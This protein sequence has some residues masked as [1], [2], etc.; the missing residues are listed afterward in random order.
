MLFQK[1]MGKGPASM[2]STS[3]PKTLWSWGSQYKGQLGLG[4][5]VSR[6]SPVQVG[7]VATWSTLATGSNSSR[8]GI[9]SDG[10]L[11]AWGYGVDG[12]LGLGDTVSR[13]SPVQIGALTTWSSVASGGPHALGIKIDGTLWA[14]GTNTTYDSLGDGTLI[15]RSSPVQI[16]TLGTWSSV[17]VGNSGNSALKSD[18]TLWSWGKNYF[19][20]LGLGTAGSGLTCSSPTQVGTL[21]TWRNVSAG[22]HNRLAIRTDGTLW[23]WGRN[24]NNGQLGLGDIIHR[25]SPVQVGTLATWSIA[26]SGGDHSLAVKTDGTLWA[27]GGGATGPLGLGD[28]IA[29]S[30]PVQIG[31]L[32]TWSAVCTGT[33]SSLAIKTNGTLWGW[34]NGSSGEQGQSDTVSRSSPVQVGTLATWTSM[35]IGTNA[36]QAIRA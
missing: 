16:G 19:G 8:F 13:S 24:N 25:S 29:R 27:W 6:S 33:Y 10:S 36:V 3:A 18:G 28:T 20:P 4:D 2:V 31:T 7:T 32:T 22:T 14:W 9:K 34:G 12:R 35:A 23:A 21:A 26:S 15:N 11:W 17:T 5:T 30:S 1:L